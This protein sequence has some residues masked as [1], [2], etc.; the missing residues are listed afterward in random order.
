MVFYESEIF[1]LGEH[2][3]ENE[4]VS[5]KPTPTPL[6]LWTCRCLNTT[7]VAYIKATSTIQVHFVEMKIVLY[8][9]TL[10]CLSGWVIFKYKHQ[11]NS[12]DDIC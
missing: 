8:K 5:E 12:L 7:A 4:V 6:R 3:S 10:K 9:G 2:R 1:V 11:N